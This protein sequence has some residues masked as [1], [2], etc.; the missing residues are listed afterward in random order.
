MFVFLSFRGLAFV[1]FNLTRL[2]YLPMSIIRF[3]RNFFRFHKNVFIFT[4]MFYF[5]RSVFILTGMFYFHRSHRSPGC[6][7][8]SAVGSSDDGIGKV[9]VEG[10]DQNV[11][12]RSTHH[13]TAALRPA[14]RL[15]RQRHRRLRFHCYD[16]VL[17]VS[18]IIYCFIITRYCL[19]YLLLFFCL[20]MTRYF[21]IYY[22]LFLFGC[23]V[24]IKTVPHNNSYYDFIWFFCYCLFCGDID[25][26]GDYSTIMTSLELVI[27]FTFFNAISIKHLLEKLKFL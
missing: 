5:H 27:Y 14:A 8:G 23:T 10:G 24:A 22:C 11:L 16:E 17:F 9:Q 18:F 2:V 26:A 25:F 19:L 7:H 1:L 21:L 4:G 12:P 13:R 20:I 15:W 3:R 6:G